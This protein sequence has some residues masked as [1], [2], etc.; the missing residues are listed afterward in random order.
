MV[1]HAVYITSLHLTT[2]VQQ[3]RRNLSNKWIFDP[4]NLVNRI[5]VKA[6]PLQVD[7]VLTINCYIILSFKL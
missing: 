6:L 2:A 5:L 3:L 1:K 7:P 4:L